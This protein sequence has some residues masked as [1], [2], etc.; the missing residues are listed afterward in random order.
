MSALSAVDTISPAIQRTRSFL[1]QPFRLGTYLKLCLVA[2]ITEGL[3]N[4]HLSGPS[5]HSSHHHSSFY[6]SVTLTPAWIST[7]VAASLVLIV[8]GCIL[9]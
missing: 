4:F 5:G 3:G 8:L 1:F 2:V 7:L 6:P 9:Y